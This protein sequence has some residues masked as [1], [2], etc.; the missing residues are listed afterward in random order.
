MSNTPSAPSCDYHVPKCF[1]HIAIRVWW[2]LLT[3]RKKYSILFP[4]IHILAEHCTVLGKA[5]NAPSLFWLSQP[6]RPRQSRASF[7]GVIQPS[8]NSQNPVSNHRNS[9]RKTSHSTG[10]SHAFLGL[11]S[12]L[13]RF[14]SQNSCSRGGASEVMLI[15]SVLKSPS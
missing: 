10:S 5:A 7:T 6:I 8:N 15:R 3:Y 12:L 14:S 13:M 1:D 2:N 11:S 4:P 9:S